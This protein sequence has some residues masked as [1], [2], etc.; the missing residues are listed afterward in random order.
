MKFRN[1][2][3]LKNVNN[4]Y[5]VNIMNIK[6]FIVHQVSIFFYLAKNFFV[7]FCSRASRKIIVNEKFNH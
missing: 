6:F 4:K 5:Y 1:E 3:D 7:V 2:F